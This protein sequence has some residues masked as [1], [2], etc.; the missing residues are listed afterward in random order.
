MSAPA[1][2]AMSPAPVRMTPCTDASV[3]AFSKAVFKS[4]KVGAFNALR[5]FG[6]LTVM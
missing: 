5:T 3:L 2:R 1:M 4:I 6:R